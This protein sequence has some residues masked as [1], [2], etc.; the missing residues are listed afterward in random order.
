MPEVHS[1]VVVSNELV[2]DGIAHVKERFLSEYRN[3]A[4]TA[5]AGALL[6]GL[7][8]W[9]AHRSRIAEDVAAH[10]GIERVNHV[11]LFT[12]DGANSIS[13][14]DLTDVYASRIF[15]T[16]P[17]QVPLDNKRPQLPHV[18]HEQTAFIR[19]AFGG[20]AGVRSHCGS[21][22]MNF[23]PFLSDKGS[24][25]E[26]L[27]GSLSPQEITITEGVVT[28]YSEDEQVAISGLMYQVHGF[29]WGAKLR[30]APDPILDP[31]AYSAWLHAAPVPQLELCFAGS[32]IIRS[33]MSEASKHDPDFGEVGRLPVEFDTKSPGSHYNLSEL[34][35]RKL[36]RFTQLLA[37]LWRHEF[38]TEMPSVSD[39]QIAQGVAPKELQV[40][41]SS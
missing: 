13:C 36:E 35:A 1:P 7:A 37:V 12:E 26:M 27:D 9:E 16:P 18:P 38:G 25:E 3:T 8:L 31:E 29:V 15:Q 33:H 34:G 28:R 11:S 14:K 40:P 24:Y 41:Q 4:K 10:G 17:L 6:N 5:L 39:A 20:A 32:D 19:M 22:N 21:Y 30:T 2:E 23:S